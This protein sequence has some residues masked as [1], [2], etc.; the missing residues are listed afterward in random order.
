LISGPDTFAH[1]AWSPD[2]SLIAFSRFMTG[3]ASTIWSMNPDGT[4]PI[5]LTDRYGADPN[6]S[7]DGQQLVFTS[8]T[9]ASTLGE[10][11][12]YRQ[13]FIMDADGKKIREG[14]PDLPL[15]FH[16][17]SSTLSPDGKQLAVVG[18]EANPRVKRI[19]TSAILVVDC[20]G[21]YVNQISEHEG[22]LIR[23][24]AVRQNTS[25]PGIE[26]HH[27]SNFAK[28]HEP[29]SSNGYPKWSSDGKRI[30]FQYF[31]E[32]RPVEIHLVDVDGSNREVYRLPDVDGTIEG[33]IVWRPRPSK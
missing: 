8:I 28:P 12:D 31:A 19:P 16:V 33:R 32:H 10:S 22:Y 3:E 13:P 7:N 1:P 29:S 18:T 20:Q 11:L 30:A 4:N 25:L 24:A 23:T 6:W 2:G 15:A 27:L 14:A 21:R 5:R 17:D 26:I 9:K